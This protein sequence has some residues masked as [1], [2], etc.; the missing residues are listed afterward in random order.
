V[1]AAAAEL[2]VEPSSTLRDLA[3]AA[4]EPWDGVLARHRHALLRSAREVI[5]LAEQCGRAVEAAP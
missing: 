3:A 2:G 4:P 5:R 1:Q